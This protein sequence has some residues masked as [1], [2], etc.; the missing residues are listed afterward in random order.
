MQEGELEPLARWTADTTPIDVDDEDEEVVLR[1]IDDQTVEISGR[2]MID[3]LNE[4]A[5]QAE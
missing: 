3:D 1:V 4:M 2:M 5:P